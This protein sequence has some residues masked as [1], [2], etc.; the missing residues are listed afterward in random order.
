MGM[1]AQNYKNEPG[2]HSLPKSWIALPD[3]LLAN[4]S[5]HPIKQQIFI[6]TGHKITKT[7]II[8]LFILETKKNILIENNPWKG[9]SCQNKN[10]EQ[11][12]TCV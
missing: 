4:R 8:L 1:E 10:L 12:K 3:L 7:T 11:W 5:S 2:G 6:P 9:S